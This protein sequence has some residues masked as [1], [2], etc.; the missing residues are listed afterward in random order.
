MIF[1]NEVLQV[2][3]LFINYRQG[4][5]LKFLKSSVERTVKAS[6]TQTRSRDYSLRFLITI[7]PF[8]PLLGLGEY[9]I[10]NNN[11]SYYIHYSSNGE[12]EF[13]MCLT[14]VTKL[15]IF[16]TLH[17]WCFLIGLVAF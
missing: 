15:P 6:E 9:H 10:Y 4:I 3:L 13:F 1:L 12:P 8:F 11:N 14:T 2:S 7:M 16:M 17:L 5:S